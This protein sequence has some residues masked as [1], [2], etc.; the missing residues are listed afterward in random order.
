RRRAAERGRDRAGR[1]GPIRGESAVGWKTVSDRDSGKGDR[2]R[3]HGNGA[4]GT[5]VDGGRRVPNKRRLA[6][7]ACVIDRLNLR[8]CERARIEADF[9]E[10]AGERIARALGITEIEIVASLRDET[11]KV[12][13]RLENAVN[14]ERP[15]SSRL[16][17]GQGIMAPADPG[18]FAAHCH[19][20]PRTRGVDE[21]SMKLS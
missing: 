8:C 7:G 21:S 5:G 2:V 18:A 16:I 4:I 15:Y 13:L 14:V 3:R 1:L 11:P 10:G 19:F 20:V 6:T 12:T 17:V 9:I